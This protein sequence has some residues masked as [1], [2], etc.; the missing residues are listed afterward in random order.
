M[1]QQNC[2]KETM[3]SGNPLQD[4]NN[5]KGVNISE[6]NFL[7]NRKGVNRQRQ[8]KALKP[9]MTS[10]RFKVTSFI[11][12]TLNLDFTL[13]EET[14]L[15]PLRQIDVARAT[16][17]S[18]GV[19]QEK[20]IDDLECGRESKFIRILK[21][22]HEVHSTERQTSQG[23]CVVRREINKNSSNCQT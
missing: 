1:E 3:N 7:A 18:L 4:G 16:Y 20:R 15:I 6:K 5:L 14:F 17:T 9:E 10:G 2:L 19:L 23:T 22:I 11:V 21:R 13:R 8:K 12:N